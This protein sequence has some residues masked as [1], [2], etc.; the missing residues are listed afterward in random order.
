MAALDRVQLEESSQRYLP[1]SM[2]TNAKMLCLTYR[3]E[4]FLPFMAS[5]IEPRLAKWNLNASG[6]FEPLPLNV[7]PLAA[8]IWTQFAQ[9]PVEIQ[10][11][12]MRALR[13]DP[14][15]VPCELVPVIHDECTYNAN[16]G[17]HHQWILG[18]HNPLRKKSRGASRQEVD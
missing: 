4:T 11:E 18:V 7:D 17:V 14:A 15:A 2:D 13:N 8:H 12:I 10:F 6:E 5:I 3:Q 1:T 16:D 9:Y